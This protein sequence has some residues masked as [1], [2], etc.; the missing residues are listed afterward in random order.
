VRKLTCI[1]G[2]LSIAAGS[3]AQLLG[4]LYLVQSRDQSGYVNQE[5]PDSVA[6][7]TI[8]GNVASFTTPVS[9]S[10]VQQRGYD[11][12]GWF[13][14]LGVPT[15][16]LTIS[17]FS[18]F[19]SSQHLAGA[20]SVGADIV[21]DGVRPSTLNNIAGHWYNFEV[22]ATGILLDP[23]TYLVTSVPIAPIST[24][25]QGMTQAAAV[26]T[27]DSWIRG[28]FSH[29]GN[30]ETLAASGLGPPNDVELGMGINGTAV[31]EPA[32]LAALGFGLWAASRRKRG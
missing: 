29:G 25:G 15:A 16:H 12:G 5:F 4:N 10:N 30:W 27:R 7:T 2:S 22:D 14:L 24:H 1:L 28:R 26:P 32:T 20:P 21:Y 23:G 6:T 11:A 3:Y 18:G 9:L 19:P 8:I 17:R 13:V 31:P